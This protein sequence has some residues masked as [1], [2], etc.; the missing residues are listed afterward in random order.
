MKKI[1]ASLL[2]LSLLLS[3]S[4]AMAADINFVTAG[5]ASTF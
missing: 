5:T 1:L 4:C 2:C 3:A